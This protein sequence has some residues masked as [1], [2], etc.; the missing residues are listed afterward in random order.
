LREATVNGFSVVTE[1]IPGGWVANRSRASSGVVWWDFFLVVVLSYW[2][3]VDWSSVVRP[4]G[5]PSRDVELDE[6][7]FACRLRGGLYAHRLVLG[8]LADHALR[9]GLHY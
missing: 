5:L 9:V 2:L 7:F 1:A 8:F 4:R 3:F 6:T